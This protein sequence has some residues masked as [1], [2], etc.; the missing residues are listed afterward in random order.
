[1]P[2]RWGPCV[3]PNVPQLTPSPLVYFGGTT[4]TTVVGLGG[5][6]THVIGEVGS[7]RAGAHSCLPH[8]IMQLRK[9]L[10]ESLPSPYNEKPFGDQ[11]LG[12]VYLATVLGKGPSQELEFVAQRLAHGTCPA[13]WRDPGTPE[14]VLVG[15]PLY[16]AMSE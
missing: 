10:G 15:T 6:A 4:E 7:T 2:M 14:T 12:G 3:F 8:F 9:E 16:V 5:S 11:A 13:P 1:M